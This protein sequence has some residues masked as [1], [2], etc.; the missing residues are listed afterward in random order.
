[1][2]VQGKDCILI[3]KQRDPQ[4]QSA[5]GTGPSATAWK[6]SLLLRVTTL[7]IKRMSEMYLGEMPIRK[8]VLQENV[9]RQKCFRPIVLE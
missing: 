7:I 5:A 4:N 1:M 6:P 3:S 2:H 9:I 8:I